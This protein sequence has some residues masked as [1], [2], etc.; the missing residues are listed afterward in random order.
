MGKR[1]EGSI[2][3]RKSGAWSVSLE[4]GGV[5]KCTTCRTEADARMKLAEWKFQAADNRPFLPGKRGWS[6][7]RFTMEKHLQDFLVENWE[8]TELGAKWAIYD[9]G[10][11]CKTSVGRIDILARSKKG[12][13]WLVVELKRGATADATIGQLLRYMGWVKANIVHRSEN[14]Q[15]MIIA[16]EADEKLLYAAIQTPGVQVCVYA[17][18]FAILPVTADS[19]GRVAQLM[20]AG[21]GR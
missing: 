14:V 5:R 9:K 6:P 7:H 4:A 21:D 10:I 11:E 8:R 15:G 1:G 12:D 20:E 13:G 2:S 18:R 19:A 17:L 3:R 16:P